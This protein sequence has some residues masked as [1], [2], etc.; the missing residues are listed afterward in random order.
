MDV[1]KALKQAFHILN[2]S[3]PAFPA[4]DRIKKYFAGLLFHVAA[5]GQIP[6]PESRGE[7]AVETVIKVVRR[8]WPETKVTL[9]SSDPPSAILADIQ[10]ILRFSGFGPEEIPCEEEVD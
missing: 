8:L 5:G 3:D 4:E 10:D 1:Q 9:P 2:G 6:D 7:R